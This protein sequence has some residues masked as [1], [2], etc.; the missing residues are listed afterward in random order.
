VISLEKES[1]LLLEDAAE[2]E[3]HLVRG[4]VGL[5]GEAPLPRELVAAEHAEH[6]LRV[7][8]VHREQ[9]YPST[10]SSNRGPLSPTGVAVARAPSE[11]A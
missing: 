7:P 9:H 2:Q 5:G 6:R 8:D 4:P 3:R 10:S 11:A 1:P